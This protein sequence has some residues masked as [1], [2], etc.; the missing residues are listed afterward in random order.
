MPSS[1][2]AEEKKPHEQEWPEPHRRQAEVTEG[3]TPNASSEE[4]EKGRMILVVVHR[5]SF[6][7]G[8]GGL[9]RRFVGLPRTSAM[10]AIRAAESSSVGDEVSLSS[11]LDGQSRSGG[12]DRL[13]LESPPF[14][15]C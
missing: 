11:S 3:V 15:A 4:S 7:L 10:G 13:P 5:R 2:K 6:P 12:S 1:A 14:L 9:R 8:G